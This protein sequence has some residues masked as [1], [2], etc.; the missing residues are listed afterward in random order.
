MLGDNE[1]MAF[2]A[3]T[4][5]EK[6]KAFYAEILGLRLVEDDWFAIVFSAGGTT[7]RIQKVKEFSPLPFTVLGWKVADLKQTVEGLSK[8]GVT[9]ERYPGMQQDDAGIWT[10][11]D[12]AGKVCW[13]KDPDGNTLS[14]TQFL[15]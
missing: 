10:T 7:L 1:V 9:L 2:V 5:P 12:G 15:K 8:K 3:T 4:Q 14:L 6:A 11:P 13:F